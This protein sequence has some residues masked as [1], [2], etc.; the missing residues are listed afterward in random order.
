M[1]KN[2][3]LKIAF[4]TISILGST[5]V[6]A[7]CTGLPVQGTIQTQSI[8]ASRQVGVITMTSITNPLLFK[9]LIGKG[10]LIIRGGI[11]GVIT[12]NLGYEIHLEHHIGFPNIGAIDSYNDV[13]TITGELDDNYNVPVVEVAPL[14]AAA[15]P[16][17]GVF[18]GFTFDDAVA[19]GTVGTRS[20][21]NSFTYTA[22]AHKL[23]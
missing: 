3:A 7:E 21:T 9:K 2:S 8:D 11:S 22:C 6:S 20:G 10:Q 16:F 18:S 5:A 19:I 14:N 15:A 13:A 17:G 23:P 12:E 1:K 4:A